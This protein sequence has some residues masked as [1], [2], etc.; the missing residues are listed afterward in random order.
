MVSQAEVEERAGQQPYRSIFIVDVRLDSLVVKVRFDRPAFLAIALGHATFTSERIM[1]KR[2]TGRY[3]RTSAGGE[4][5][6]AFVPHALPPVRL[7]NETKPPVRKA[8][9]STPTRHTWTGPARGPS[10]AIKADLRPR[11]LRACRTICDFRYEGD[12]GRATLRPGLVL[13]VPSLG[14][15]PRTCGET[16][17]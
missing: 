11:N 7:L 6:R 5:V 4:P 3:E 15:R 9:A 12:E 16:R 17:D 10:S 13:A 8:T 1:S 14:A 2:E